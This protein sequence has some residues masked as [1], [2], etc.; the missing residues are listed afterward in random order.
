MANPKTKINGKKENGVIARV[1]IAP[2]KKFNVQS[3]IFDS[4][5]LFIKKF[6]F[7]SH[8]NARLCLNLSILLR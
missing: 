2:I 8:H 1:A 7:Y 3:N 5:N 6:I 4:F